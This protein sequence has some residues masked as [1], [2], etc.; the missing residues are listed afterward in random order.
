MSQ[1]SV[2]VYLILVPCFYELENVFLNQKIEK[3]ANRDGRNFLPPFPV[4][5]TFLHEVFFFV[6][7][8]IEKQN[9][10]DRSLQKVQAEQSAIYWPFAAL[11]NGCFWRVMLQT[12]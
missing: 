5:Q 11:W 12:L 2:L 4:A 10:G 9:C 8:V 3:S 6:E 1:G 7:Q